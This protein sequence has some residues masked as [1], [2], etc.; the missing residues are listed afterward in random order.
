MSG[1]KARISNAVIRDVLRDSQWGAVF[2]FLTLATGKL[3][4]DLKYP[5][6][7]VNCKQILWLLSDR[8]PNCGR[9]HEKVVD[10]KGKLRS[11]F[12]NMDL[13]SLESYLSNGKDRTFA[14][15][16]QIICTNFDKCFTC[17]KY[18]KHPYYSSNHLCQCETDD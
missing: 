12:K 5:Y 4:R 8:S 17:K 15:I 2:D 9:C 1:C 6:Y 18:R 13:E 14:E 10:I 11:G 7:C 3:K 16:W